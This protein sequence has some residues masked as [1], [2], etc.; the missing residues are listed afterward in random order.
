MEMSTTVVLL[1]VVYRGTKN[2]LRDNT[3]S[4]DT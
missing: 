4:L 1:I 2:G 3:F